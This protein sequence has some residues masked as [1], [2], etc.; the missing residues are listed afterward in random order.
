MCY[1][2]DRFIPE[3]LIRLI[4]Y[5]LVRAFMQRAAHLHH[6]SL[7]R[8]S[9]KGSL[10]TTRHF[11]AAIHSAS[12]TPRRQD[13][14][15]AEMLAAIAFDP[16]PLRPGRSEPRARKRRPKNYHLL[17]QPRGQ[18]IVPPH[19]NRPAKKQPKKALS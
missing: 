15:I 10:D 8:L 6:A 18:M 4:S 19:R 13:A 11:A 9:F 2:C 1:P 3:I 7:D 16:V 5:N 12:S 14:L 17:T